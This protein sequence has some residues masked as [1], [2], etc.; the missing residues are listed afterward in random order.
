MVN[1]SVDLVTCST[2]MEKLTR[3]LHDL[4][5]E[6]AIYGA[7]EVINYYHSYHKRNPIYWLKVVHLVLKCTMCERL[8]VFIC[9]SLLNLC[10]DRSY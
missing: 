2:E 7:V 9:T 4:E 6:S 5:I 8:Y 1:K 10:V 3:L